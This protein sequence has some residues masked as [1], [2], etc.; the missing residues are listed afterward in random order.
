MA[1]N[2]RPRAIVSL[3][4]KSSGKNALQAQALVLLMLCHC[5]GNT[6]EV[7]SLVAIR[8]WKWIDLWHSHKL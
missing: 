1:I 5:T 6:V 7:A 4:T 8:I 2:I 3:L